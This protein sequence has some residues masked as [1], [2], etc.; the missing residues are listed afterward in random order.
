MKSSRE[1]A[2]SR[3]EDLDRFRAVQQLAYRCAEQVASAL[4]P[5][6]TERQASARLGRL[7]RENGADDWFHVPF[8][9]FGDRTTLKG[10]RNPFKFFPT[11]RRLREGMPYILDVAPI[12]GGYT[13]DIGYAGCYGENKIFDK[14]IS[15]LE[16]YRHEILEGVRA[17]RSLRA[18]YEDV[19]RLAARHGYEPAHHTYPAK[20]LA[21]QVW[22]V[23]GRGPRTVLA[24]FG[25][26]TL[27]RLGRSV[28]VGLGEGWSPLWAGSHRSDH[29]PVPG[30][31][32]IEPHLGFHGVGVKFEELMVVTED[33]AFWLDDD[34][35][36][37]R[38]WNAAKE[39]ARG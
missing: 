11:N 19:D 38:R 24:G 27:R 23:E 30:I 37:V 26:R 25:N 15:D 32:A 7:L 31:W 1:Q 3:P 35:P 39:G 14:M 21:H 5:G 20:V 33:D 13:A 10:F 28:L 17:R 29:P 9:W 8:A 4:V 2:P 22:H 34:L 6:V 16:E 12:V 36:H 18:I